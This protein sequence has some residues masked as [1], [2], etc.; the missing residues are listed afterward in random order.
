MAQNSSST[1]SQKARGLASAGWDG[2]G[3]PIL[4]FRPIVNC[5]T[6]ITKSSRYLNMELTCPVCLRLL[7]KTE[8]VME[9]LHRFCSECIQKCLR[10]TKNECPSCRIHIPSRRSLRPDPNFDALIAKI[11]PDIAAFERYEERMIAAMHKQ[12]GEQ[13]I[14]PPQP[15]PPPRSGPRL[16]TRRTSGGRTMI[17]N[18]GGTTASSSAK[19]ERGPRLSA[20]VVP[21]KKHRPHSNHHV[22]FVLRVHPLETSL[23]ALAREYLS[24]SDQLKIQHLKKFLGLKLGYSPIEDFELLIAQDHQC[25]VLNEHLSLA[26]IYQ[27]FA[28]DDQDMILHYRLARPVHL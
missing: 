15:R 4:P 16:T 10:V 21:S 3:I 11:Y 7:N 22:N 18:S 17:Q 8:I 19:R 28:P 27:S 25:V 24:T 20:A 1:P 5:E 23:N 14:Q 2:D 6:K 26:Q 13:P 12:R 9:C